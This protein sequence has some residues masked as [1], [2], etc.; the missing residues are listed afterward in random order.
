VGNIQ[1]DA[2]GAPVWGSDCLLC[3]SC[4]LACPREAISTPL[5]QSSF[6]PFIMY[7]IKRA[8]RDPAIGFQRVCLS[9]GRVAPLERG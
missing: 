6:R 2:E 7:N 3:E 1:S 5:D 8:L 9:G 4:G